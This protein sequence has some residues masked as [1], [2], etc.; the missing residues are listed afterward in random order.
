MISMEIKEISRD[1]VR[2]SIKKIMVWD[3]DNGGEELLDNIVNR[4]CKGRSV[5]IDAVSYLGNGK[6]VKE[7]KRGRYKHKLIVP[8]VD[9][10]GNIY[11]TDLYKGHSDNAVNGRYAIY[12]YTRQW[13][14]YVIEDFETDYQIERFEHGYRDDK[15]GSFKIEVKNK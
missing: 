6:Y 15:W 14:L 12:T 13:A 4:I 8:I 10:N 9:N 11:S 3:Y 1:E 2:E 5:L 7:N